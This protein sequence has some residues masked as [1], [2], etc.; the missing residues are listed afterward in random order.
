MKSPVAPSWRAGVGKND[1]FERQIKALDES[2]L[3]LI[4]FAYVLERVSLLE[5]RLLKPLLAISLVQMH[6][7]VLYKVRLP[8]ISI[9]GSPFPSYTRNNP[10]GT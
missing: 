8:L 5:V 4:S 2:V 6:C 10:V 3:C 1:E 9:T 7:H